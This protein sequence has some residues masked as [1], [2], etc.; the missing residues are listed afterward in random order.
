MKQATTTVEEPT[1]TP[2]P[3]STPYLFSQWQPW[4][5]GID[6]AVGTADLAFDFPSPVL[7]A[8]VPRKQYVNALRIHLVEENISFYTTPPGG[9]YQT[10]GQTVTGF[11][12]SAGAVQ[13]AINANF[14]WYDS[15]TVNGNFSLFG[16]A[17]SQGKIVCDP[18][19][20]APQPQPTDA[21]DVPDLT[22]TGSMAMMITNDNVVTFQVVTQAEPGTQPDTFTAIAG[23][24]QP[25]APGWPPQKAEVGPIFLVDQGF[26]QTTPHA[27]PTE[28]IAARTAV[29][30]SVYG[31]YL[32]LVTLDGCENAAWPSGGGYHDIAQWLTIAGAYTGLNLD[33]GGSTTMACR[34]SNNNPVL[35]NVP[36]GNEANP[37]TQRPVGNFF[38]VITQ[39]LS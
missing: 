36:F 35:M 17:V 4:Y 34:D 8:P 23:G 18:S 19:R 13:V 27:S 15:D 32:Y 26:T 24:P 37:G 31:Q 12:N 5:V 25:M 20:P 2:A 9:E 29:G 6:R 7:A 21:A 11:L 22:D 33:G 3:T 30:L 38:G 28:G 14:S 1:S 10:L 39:P 16:L